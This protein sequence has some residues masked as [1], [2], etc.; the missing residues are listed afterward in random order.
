MYTATYR[1]GTSQPSRHHL[2]DS[3]NINIGKNWVFRR[4]LRIAL[5]EFL[6]SF[7]A[8]FVTFETRRACTYVCGL[9][10]PTIVSVYV[11]VYYADHEQK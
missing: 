11:C 9:W 3:V 10:M 5:D 6:F 8:S 2:D 1:V 7:L 4:G